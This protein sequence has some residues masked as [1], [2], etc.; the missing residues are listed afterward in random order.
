MQ[1]KVVGFKFVS[2]TD[3]KTSELKEGY[4]V[5]LLCSPPKNEEFTGKRCTNIWVNPVLMKNTVGIFEI[6]SYYDFDYDGS[7]KF[8]VLVD[9]IP[10]KND[11][12]NEI[13]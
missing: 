13:L 2:Y 11:S 8:P 6:D 9:I 4:E 10:V 3:K 1:G 5:H 12:V 7:G